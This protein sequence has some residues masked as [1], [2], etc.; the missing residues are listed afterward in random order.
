MATIKYPSG[1][2]EELSPM[3][4]IVFQYFV[5]EDWVAEKLEGD[6]LVRA[7][8]E[9]DN[10]QWACFVQVNEEEEQCTFYSIAPI[11]VPEAKLLM[12]AEF[13]TRANHS[14]GS[15]NF[16]LDFSDGEVRF[17]TSLDVLGDQLSL[18]LFRNIVINNLAMMDQYLPGLKAVID[19]DVSPAA[20]IAQLE[21]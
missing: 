19:S 16:D 2:A 12:M 9:G 4:T 21:E 1:P 7:T 20:L 15:G 11:G 10:G 17:K 3:M 6:D 13:I 5:E 8:F 14:L 18:P